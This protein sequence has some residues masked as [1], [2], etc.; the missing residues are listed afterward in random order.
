M[1]VKYELGA[2]TTNTA[3]LCYKQLQSD[4]TAH[5]FHPLMYDTYIKEAYMLYQMNPSIPTLI[6]KW[7]VQV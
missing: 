5:L 7:E 1:T 3:V 6:L 4:H 2:I